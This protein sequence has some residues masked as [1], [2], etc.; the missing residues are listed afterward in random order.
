MVQGFGNVGSYAARLMHEQ[1]Y[2]IV[3]LA[4]RD[5]GLHNA[6]GIDI[7]RLFEYKDRNGTIQGFPGAEPADP[8][9]LMIS[10]CDVLIP[11]ATE[12]VIT[13]QNAAQIGPGSSPKEPT[14]PPRPP[15]M[16]FSRTKASSSFRTFS[17]TP[18]A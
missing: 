18:A 1:G 13:T 8:H 10:D 4:E 14:D 5:G 9:E 17:P 16:T 11:A 3:G 12:N 7:K 15:P 2:K 6:N